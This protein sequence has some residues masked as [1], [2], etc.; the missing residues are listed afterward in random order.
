MLCRADKAT[1]K[2]GEQPRRA[3]VVQVQESD[4]HAG[5]RGSHD[6]TLRG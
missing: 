6:M 2:N 4:Y 5:G 1:V 3:A